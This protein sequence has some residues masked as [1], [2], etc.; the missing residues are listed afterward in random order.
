MLGRIIGL[1]RDTLI[2]CDD[3]GMHTELQNRID[4]P[5]R[6]LFYLGERIHIPR[7]E[8]QR[9]FANGIGVG[10]QC[11]PNMRIMEIVGGANRNV[12]D[13]LTVGPTPHLVYVAIEA[14]KFAEIS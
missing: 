1:F 6:A 7:I 5:A 11:E 4:L 9:L 13:L 2:K 3:L 8:N 12:I 14:L 10:T